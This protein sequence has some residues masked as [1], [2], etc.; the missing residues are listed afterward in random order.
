[1]VV[2]FVSIK[3]PSAVLVAEVEGVASVVVVA[4]VEAHLPVATVTAV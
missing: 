3:P 4:V 2:P 1:M